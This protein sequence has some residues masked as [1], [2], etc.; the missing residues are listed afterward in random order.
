MHCWYAAPL[1]LLGLLLPSQS[2]AASREPAPVDANI[3]TAI[4]V[5][6]SI[7]GYAERLELEG[8]A[9]ALEHPAFTH[10]IEQGRAKSIGFAVFTWSSQNDF[11][12]IE[13]WQRIA[14]SEQARAVAAQL[15]ELRRGARF[16]HHSVQGKRPWR[17]S[18]G[19]DISAALE[20]GARL[21]RDAPFRSDR[22]LLNI[23]ANGVD[24]VGEP[25]DAARDTAVAAG[26][27]I[28]GM[29]LR[30]QPVV[31]DYFRA[32]VQGGPG[33]F[34]MTVQHTDDMVDAML[35]KFMLE[36]ADDRWVPSC[37]LSAQVLALTLGF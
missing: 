26:I 4:D 12:L 25:P 32:R 31:A 14:T 22:Q 11:V 13:P 8:L 10:A 1:L 2:P 30:D 29:I 19:T 35:A 17:T 23:F 15:R 20:M 27:T 34:V 7:D 16:R 3:V 18:L 36:L 5:S 33:S 21:L 6:G 37:P 9:E 24:N 28:N